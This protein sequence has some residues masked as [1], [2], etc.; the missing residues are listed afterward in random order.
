[1]PCR[2]PGPGSPPSPG[3]TWLE[4]MISAGSRPMSAQCWCRTS[5]LSRELLD[6][7]ADEVPVLRVPG[8]RAQ[9]PALAAAADADGRMGPLHPLG[10]AAGVGQLVVVAGEGRRL[11]REEPDQD[12][13]GLLEAVA[14]L[15]GRPELDA[16][17]AGFLLVPAG[18]D[19][20]LEAAVRDD[21]ERG[22]HVGEHGRVPVVDPRHEHPEAEAPRGLGQRRQRDP[23]LEAGARRVR[24]DRVEVVERPARL[25][26]VHVVRLGED[27]QHVGPARVLRCSLDG[28]AHVRTI[29]EGER[30]RARP[31]SLRA[32][33]ASG[34]ERPRPRGG[35][36]G[37]AGR[38]GRPARGRARR[39]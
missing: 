36:V 23:P 27:G 14:A 19:P 5:R 10:L 4:S 13:A 24:P 12:L 39:R 32:G 31:G 38:P 25:E 28:V 35:R 20:E 33:R 3:R 11:L 2:W 16:V 15:L 8:G 37:T 29:C 22:G 26:H 17:G 34:R 18:A 21:V 30:A 9:R 6:R 7:P 1:M